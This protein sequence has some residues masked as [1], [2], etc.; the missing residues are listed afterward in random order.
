MKLVYATASSLLPTRLAG[1]K[2]Y[3]EGRV[4]VYYN[5]QWGTV[6]DD[7]WDLLDAI[8]VCTQLGFAGALGA[9]RNS[10]FERGSRLLH[11][12]KHHHACNATLYS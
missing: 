9:T 5:N 1:G 7:Q 2:V 3:G 11:H 12:W 8:V 10:F 4:E 6:C